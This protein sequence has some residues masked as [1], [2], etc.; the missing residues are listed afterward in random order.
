MLLTLILVSNISSVAAVHT[1][2]DS[3]APITCEQS[4]KPTITAQQWIE[5][6][7]WDNPLTG[8]TVYFYL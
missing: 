7:F 1:H 4:D 8:E 2:M 6:A 3:I 5:N